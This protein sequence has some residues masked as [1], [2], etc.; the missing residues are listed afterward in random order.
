M[1]AILISIQP[2]WAIRILNGE[3]TIEIRSSKPICDL[4]IDVYIYFTRSQLKSDSIDDVAQYCFSSGK[5]VAKFTL[6][7]IIEI[8]KYS[9]SSVNLKGTCI[10]YDEYREYVGNRKCYAWYIDNL[11]I[12]DKPKELSEFNHLKKVKSE[13]IE[14]YDLNP[15]KYTKIIQDRLTKAPQSWCY[16]E[17]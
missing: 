12:F 16:V 7:K 2:E 14:Q 10:T 8:D 15:R 6:N 3:K 11:E 4:P 17:V 1:K 13:Y 5:V 9:P